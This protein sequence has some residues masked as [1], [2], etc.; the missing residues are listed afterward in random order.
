M[1]ARSRRLPALKAATVPSGSAT[2]IEKTIVVR[3]S[4]I[5]GSMRWPISVVTGLPE[6]IEVPRSPCISDQT[7]VKNCTASGSDRPSCSRMRAT[8][9][10]VA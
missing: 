2:A 9:S 6:K 3:A 4:S 5:V 10:A 8:S 7:Q 1:T